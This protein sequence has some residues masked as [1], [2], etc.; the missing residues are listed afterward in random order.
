MVGLEKERDTDRPC[1]IDPAR[2]KVCLDMDK[3]TYRKVEVLP[4]STFYLGNDTLQR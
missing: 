2:H 3:E 4:V 1:W